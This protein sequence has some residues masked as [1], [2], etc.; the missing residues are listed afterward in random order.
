M[1]V[2]TY[3]TICYILFIL[4]VSLPV[5]S[6]CVDIGF[7]QMQACIQSVDIKKDK[8][9]KLKKA[10]AGSLSF[11]FYQYFE[12][13]DYNDYQ[14]LFLTK[15]WF[16]MT[17]EE[18]NEWRIFLEKANIQLQGEVEI[19]TNGVSLG[20]VK[21]TYDLGEHRIYET[22]L[23][24]KT[25]NAWRP[26]SVDEEQQYLMLA[27]L[28]R[29]T[30][31]EYLDG[32]TSGIAQ[33]QAVADPIVK[34]GSIQPK[35]MTLMKDSLKVYHTTEYSQF[36]ND[37]FEYRTRQQF[38]EDRNHDA[39]FKAFLEEMQVSGENQDRV[40]AVIFAQDYLRAAALADEYSEVTYTYAPF[41]DKIREVYGRD[42]IRKW[43][44][45]TNQW[46]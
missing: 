3:L 42:R 38:N 5:A 17:V 26:A 15:D 2:K 35:M 10:Q 19:Q 27:N 46:N 37:E 16:G 33:R 40:M 39:A 24:K 7:T 28:V 31:V 32:L 14:R 1:T 11:L 44:S 6:Q 34:N 36:F 23:A 22:F 21:Y 20:I 43:D 45:V 41:I 9:S 18:F 25:G 30:N 29:F 13:A 4:M 12:G 8:L